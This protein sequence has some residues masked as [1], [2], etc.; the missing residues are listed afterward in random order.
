MTSAPAPPVRVDASRAAL[1]TAL[2]ALPLAGLVLLLARPSLDVVWQHHPSHFW[3]VLGVGAL[4]AVLA[5]AT[6]TAA[7]RRGDA[8]VLLVCLA[9]LAC[10]GFLGLHALATPRVLLESPSAGFALAT[11]IGLAIGAVFA[12]SSS[13]PLPAARSL[14]VMRHAGR[15]RAGLLAVMALWAVVSLAALPPLDSPSAPE[16]ASG[17]LLALAVPAVGLYALAAVRYWRLHAWRRHRS[18]VLL[19]MSMAFVLLAEAMVAVAVARNWHASWWEW[20]LL[21]LIAFVLVARS[22]QRQWHEERFADL[23]LDQTAGGVREM[24]VLFADLEGFTRFAE[25]RAPQ[26]VTAMLNAYFEAAIPAVVRCHGGVVDR[27]IGDAVM[28]TFNRRGD[29]PD[30]PRRAAAAALDLQAETARVAAAHPDWPRFR[31]GVNT[32]EV[33]VAV[34]GTAGART[35]TVIGDTVNVAARLEGKA[36]AGGVAIGA[37]TRAALPDARVQSLGRVELKGKSRAQEAYLLVA[38]D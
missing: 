20:H 4:S 19:G 15:L 6:G 5:Y 12:A 29:Q 8:R 10:A 25:R 34:L 31:V 37:A 17:P 27:M 21:M 35:H 14:W 11:P 26:E 18:P 7:D 9:F 16:R 28:V 3:L 23:Y 2:L 13:A 24:S 33:S 1:V 22:A 30:H 38:L 32:G 36:P